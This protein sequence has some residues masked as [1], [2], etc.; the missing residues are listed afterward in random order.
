M[1][2]TVKSKWKILS[3]SGLKMIAMVTM[4]IDHIACFLLFDEFS[5]IQPLFTVGKTNVSIY[6]LL[7]SVGRLAF[8]IYCFLLAEGFLHTRNRLR[9]GLNLLIF[10]LISEIPWNFVHGGSLLYSAQNVFFTLFFGYVCLYLME[11]EKC[12]T[13]IRVCGVLGIFVL[14][15]FFKADYGYMG[16]AAI[17]AMYLL[18]KNSLARAAVCTCLFSSTW[19]AALAFVP[20]G[21]YNGERGFIKGRVGKYICYIFYP[22]HLLVL[23]VLRFKLFL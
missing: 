22:L 12:P 5:L 1:E 15:Y 2:G 9:Y 10:A 6:W 3:G 4:L 13:V 14:A 16:V 17:I 20:I 18:R 23:G 8:P 11:I 19:R 7:R 21:L